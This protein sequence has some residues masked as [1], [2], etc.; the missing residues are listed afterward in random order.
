MPDEEERVIATM[1]F[2]QKEIVRLQSHSKAGLTTIDWMLR[3]ARRH[4]PLLGRVMRSYFRDHLSRHRL[5]IEREEMNAQKKR[6]ELV[7]FI[8][9]IAKTSHVAMEQ[10]KS[11]QQTVEQILAENEAKHEERPRAR[12]S[13]ALVRLRAENA[14]LMA[15]N[16]A[17]HGKLTQMQASGAES[18][19]QRP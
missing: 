15:E 8:R 10:M 11:V 12:D 4:N 14:A 17:L 16:M 1:E 7:D 3:C 5:R 9:K 13:N 2:M 18:G 6:Q 19:S